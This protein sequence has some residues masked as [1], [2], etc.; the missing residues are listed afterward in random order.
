VIGGTLPEE[1]RRV[2]SSRFL[3]PPKDGPPIS[4]CGLHRLS[5]SS[6]DSETVPGV[7]GLG[8]LPGAIILIWAAITSM[9]LLIGLVALQLGYWI[10]LA[11]PLNS[12]TLITTVSG[13]VRYLLQERTRRRIERAFGRYFSRPPIDAPLPE[14]RSEEEQE[15]RSAHG[16]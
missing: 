10:P 8:L 16:D 2:S 5:A 14:K 11:T 1:D 12:L 4:P 9:L 3:T 15:P 13:V 6:G 7:A